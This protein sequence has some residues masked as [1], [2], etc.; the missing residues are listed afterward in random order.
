MSFFK[1]DEYKRDFR[2]FSKA[3]VM[4]DKSIGLRRLKY[5]QSVSTWE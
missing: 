1:R 4:H 5:M 2:S 3:Y